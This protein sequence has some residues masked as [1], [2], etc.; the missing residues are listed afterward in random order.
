[1]GILPEP[2]PVFFAGCICMVCQSEG[3]A[4][5]E[6]IW[7]LRRRDVASS[8]GGDSIEVSLTPVLETLSV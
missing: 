5:L 4:I 2:Y 7:L 8:D 6:E 1:M 3:T